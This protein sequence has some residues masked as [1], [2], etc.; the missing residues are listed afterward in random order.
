MGG[1]IRA[2]EMLDIKRKTLASKEFS[3]SIRL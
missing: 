2:N 1:Q 3:V